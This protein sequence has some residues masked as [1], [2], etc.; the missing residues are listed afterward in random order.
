MVMCQ[1]GVCP[2]ENHVGSLLLHENAMRVAQDGNR[3]TGS[4]QQEC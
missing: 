4:Q 2:G 1:D 3:P